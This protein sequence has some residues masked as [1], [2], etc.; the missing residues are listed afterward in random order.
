[1]SY[2]PIEN[3]GVIGDLHS[4]AL[5]GMNGSIDF[6]CFPNFDSPTI[7]AALLD[8]ERGGR[9]ELTPVKRDQA[10]QK[11]LYLPDSNI[12]LTR[13]LFENGVSE[14]SDFMP[15]DLKRRAHDLVRRAKTI[16]G[17]I[18]YQMVCDPRF[19]YART[20][21][22]VE[23]ISDGEILFIPKANQL[24]SLRL[25]TSVPVDIVN[26]ACVARFKLSSGENA[27]F[28]LEEARESEESPSNTDNFTSEAFKETLNFWRHWTG[29]S[30]YQGRWREEVNRS[31]LILKLLTFEPTGAIVAA[32]TFALPERLGGERNWDYR[33]TWI[34]DASFTL[35]ALIRLGYT[36]EAASFMQWIEARCHELGSKDSLQVMYSIEGRHELDEE[37]LDHFEGYCGS[38]PVRIGNA[39]YRQLQLDIYGELMDCVYLYDKYGMPIAHELW[40]DILRLL[41]W[42]SK[43]WKQRDAGIW[44]VRGKH[45]EFLY[46]RFLCWVALDR[47]IR[48]AARRSLPA[49]LEQWL[50]ARDEIYT[51]IFRSF[52]SPKRKA[53]VQYK[54]SDALDASCL[55][56]PLLRFISPRDPMWLSTLRAV[57]SELVFDSLLYRYQTGDGHVDGL[58]GD[59]GTFNMCSFWFTE[60]LSRAGDIQKAR[61]N[62]EKMLGY[63]NHLGLYSEELGTRA[64][65]LGNFPQAFTHLALIS[66]A[67]DIDRRLS[68]TAPPL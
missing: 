54:G 65:H 58:Q 13:F 21:H 68:Q 63:A 67:Y 26:G 38:Q 60:C 53:F 20:G 4:V 39:A 9:F 48:L 24:P 36:E 57:E 17:E 62:F 51:E 33:F 56:L 37:T 46:S 66:A 15:I 49:P 25:R 44:E 28:V 35:Y 18:E 27:A 12:L 3:Y 14:I 55:L 31:A 8:Q 16:R 11:Q 45:R 50:K 41:D 34:R 7:F 19:D 52:W 40:N 61:Y 23:R 29:K 2:Q 59:E 47:G 5:V 42:V 22:T 10:R 6:M 64:Q 43:H 32:P 30:K 1:M